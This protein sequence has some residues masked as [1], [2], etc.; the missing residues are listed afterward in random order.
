MDDNNNML[1]PEEETNMENFLLKSKLV[2]KGG[3]LNEDS[4][5]D[6]E[7]ENIFL[8]NV[9]AFEEADIKPV[10]EII[11][12]DLKEYPAVETLTATEINKFLSKLNRKLQTHNM[13]LDLQKNVPAKLIYKFL[14][15][16]YLLEM[17][18]NVPGFNVIIDGCSG[19]CPSCFQKDYCS[20]K[21]NIW[22]P[23]KLEA[24]I[25]RRKNDNP[26]S[27]NDKS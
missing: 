14:V 21:D 27:E 22:T 26:S 9:I 2:L 8:K 16:D 4:D 3:I 5:I 15:E 24:E 23:E 19:D 10:Y 6:P 11:G 20:I 12:I 18:Q 7:L 17:T 13:Q 1:T 25:R